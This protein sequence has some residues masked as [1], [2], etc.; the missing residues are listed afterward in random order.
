M[1]ASS[2]AR[3]RLAG[4]E[5]GVEA[6]EAQ[7]PQMILGDALQRVADEADVALLEIGEPAEIVEQLARL[8]DRPTAR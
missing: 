5:A 6:E 2:A 8:R 3:I 7:D 1:H 4:V